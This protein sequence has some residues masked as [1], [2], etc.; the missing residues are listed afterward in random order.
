MNSTFFGLELSRRALES[1]QN[2]LNITGHNIAN[3]NTQGYTRQIANLTAT[4]PQSIPASGRSLSLGTGVTLDTVTRARD[5]FVDRQFRWETS[6]QQYWAGKQDGLS[7][8]E[9]MFNEP[10]DN[11]LSN[12][13]NQF[14]TAWSDLSKNPENMGARSVVRERAQTLTGSFQNTAQQISNMTD[15][16]EATIKVQIHQINV[17]GQQIKD[18]NDQIKRAEV[19]G[20]NP[21]DLR[22]KRDAL[23]DD[24]SKLVSVRVVETKD[25]NFTDRNV[26]SFKVIIGNENSVNNTLADDSMVRLLED[27][28]SQNAGGFSRVVWSDDPNPANPTD[29]DLGTKLGALAASIELRDQDLPRFRAQLDTLAQG[30]ASAVNALHQTGQGLTAEDLAGINFFTDG[31]NSPVLDAQ[32]LPVVTAATITLNSVIELD[33]N[34]IATGTI[35]LDTSTN[36]ATHVLD[37]GGNKLVTVGDGSIA[38]GISSLSTGWDALKSLIAAGKF[39]ATG[40]NPVSASSLGDY[41]GANVAMMGVDVQQANRMKA[42][43]DILVANVTNQRESFIGVSLDEEMT[44]LVK[45]Q[46]SYSAA[47]RM[48]TMMDDMLDTIINRMGMTR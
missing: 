11:S 40:Q 27:P 8:V 39:G 22:D 45:F 2:A 13:M 37:S 46:K 28:P 1:Q 12:D 25:P 32:G 5:D 23:V 26:N 18:L 38:Q 41:Y 19:S 29:V 35:P 9:G 24:L 15:N 33:V 34:R 21:N 44:N 47:A 4:T 10:S 17:Y 3:A 48:V 7:K 30:I 20:D 36:P 16:M 6:K 14:W 43:E 31:S 42:G